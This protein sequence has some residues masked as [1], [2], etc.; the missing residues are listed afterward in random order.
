MKTSAVRTFP[1]PSYGT[2]CRIRVTA[3]VHGEPS[4][5]AVTAAIGTPGQLASGNWQAG[6]ML[7]EDA[8]K[9]WPAIAPLIALHL[10][11]TET[12]EP[13]HA[14]ANGFYWLE[15]AASGFGSQYHGGSG[16]DGKPADE[17]LRIFA[18]HC[19]VSLEEAQGIARAV[20][21]AFRDAAAGVALDSP[22][23]SEIAHKERAKA[24]NAAAKA[25]W[26]VICDD[27]RPRWKLEAEAGMELL[28]SLVA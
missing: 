15:G 4:Y 23:V 11:N 10:S 3:E 1:K 26:K 6:G 25:D 18:E 5:F 22:D 19:R 12:G 2:N 24:G 16:K 9:A 20:S 21:D 14:E 28:R 27:M 7:H 13:M 8:V 17:C